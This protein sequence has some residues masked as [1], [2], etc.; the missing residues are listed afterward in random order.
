M[1]M[2]MEVDEEHSFAVRRSMNGALWQLSG[3]LDPEVSADATAADQLESSICTAIYDL[4]NL[5]A[6]PAGTRMGSF[7]PSTARFV[8]A[9]ELGAVE[10]GP[11]GVV[12]KASDSE[13]GADLKTLQEDE[14]NYHVLREAYFMAACRGHPSLVSLSAVGRDPRTGEYC[15]VMEHVGPSLY[16]VIMENRQQG[17]FPERD[18]RRIMRQVLSGAKAMH[19]RGVVHRAIN[20]SNVL[21]AA[22]DGGNVVVKIGNFGEATAMSER[23]VAFYAMLSQLAPECLLDP[24]QGAKN[25]AAIDMWSI[26]CLMLELLT[27]EDH[28]YLNAEGDD[29]LEGQQLQRI[30]DVLGLSDKRTMEAM[31]PAVVDVELST[32]VQ[33][34]RVQLRGERLRELVPRNVLSDSGFAL[35]QGLLM[36]SPKARIRAAEALQLPWFADDNTDDDSPAVVL[37]SWLFIGTL[38]LFFLMPFVFLIRLWCVRGAV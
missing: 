2:D 12:V 14:H 9:C 16:D 11:L 27:G 34:H 31:K 18:V 32:E 17:F 26:G 22:N 29:D 7:L 10:E 8:E 23:N 13:T 35:L 38:A 28:F 4:G 37:V 19:D 1:D 5:A 3:L 21:V 15:L 25:D 6:S 20:S 36:Y 30:D 33:R 24:L